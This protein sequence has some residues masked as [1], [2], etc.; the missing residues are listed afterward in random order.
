MKDTFKKGG[1]IL[2]LCLTLM[3]S[4]AYASA[5][6]QLE[7][8]T[9]NIEMVTL[10]AGSQIEVAFSGAEAT[11]VV[12]TSEESAIYYVATPGNIT[13]GY[14]SPAEIQEYDNHIRSFYKAIC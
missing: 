7:T 1:G 14:T 9:E 8:D 6:T 2:A 12:F 3:F 13:Q 11:G 10:Q 4:V 5:D